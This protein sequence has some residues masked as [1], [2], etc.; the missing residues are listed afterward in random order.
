V[1]EVKL[2]GSST[3]GRI[4]A[5]TDR[6]MP[7]VMHACPTLLH[8]R[9]AVWDADEKLPPQQRD[10][11]VDEITAPITAHWKGWRQSAIEVLRTT[12]SEEITSDA[13]VLPW[14]LR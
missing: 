4:E 12:I 11:I 13:T 2:M 9:Q 6:L 7:E 8:I 3:A 5:L 1:K 10:N 14:D